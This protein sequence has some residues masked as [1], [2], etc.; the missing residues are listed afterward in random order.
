MLRTRLQVPP[1]SSFSTRMWVHYVLRRWSVRTGSLWRPRSLMIRSCIA[2][3]QDAHVWCSWT[4]VVLGYSVPIATIAGTALH[5]PAN[6]GGIGHHT[7]PLKPLA[8]DAL[9]V[10][11][12]YPSGTDMLATI[13]CR[14]PVV[15][16]ADST[17][18]SCVSGSMGCLGGTSGIQIVSTARV[19]ARSP[20]SRATSRWSLTHMI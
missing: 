13:S 1:K 16:V 4:R 5:R 19:S 6:V 15:Q 11:H 18:A 9:I 8:K 17:S 10:G 3:T 20:R 2:R 14:V 12:A 7:W